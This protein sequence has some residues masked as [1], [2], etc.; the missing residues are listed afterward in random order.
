MSDVFSF[1][2]V[3]LELLTGRRCL[4]KNRPNREQNLV[5]WAK[6][7]MKDSHKVDRIM[8]PRLEGQYSSEGARKAATLAH[9]CLSQ[10][11]KSR[12]TMSCVVKTLQ[13][14]LDLTHDISIPFVYVVPNDERK[15][16]GREGKQEQVPSG[17]ECRHVVMEGK[18][19]G[20]ETEANGK[21]HR[22]SRKGYRHKHRIRSLRSN[23]VFS[24]TALYRTLGT[25]LYSPK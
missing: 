14:L 19:D 1:G 9:H 8:D 21:G 5:D 16:D 20:K 24:D 4:D 2:V 3:L 7:F 13:P 6:P 11:P 10:H 22:R 12:P 18:Q 23:A 15:S 17:N 25:G